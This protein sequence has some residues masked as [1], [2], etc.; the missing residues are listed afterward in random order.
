MT[1][2]ATTHMVTSRDATLE[3]LRLIALR[4]IYSKASEPLDK[5]AYTPEFELMYASYVSRT[6]HKITLAGFW[7]KMLSARKA[8]KLERK[9]R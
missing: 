3:S 5:L 9:K 8:G 2:K 1:M 7:T 4:D 6:G